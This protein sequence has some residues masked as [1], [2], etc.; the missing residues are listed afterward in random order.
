VLRYNTIS[1]N[2]V[3]AQS[4]SHA[5]GGGLYFNFGAPDLV[6][7][8]I[9]GNSVSESYSVMYDREGGGIYLYG[10]N[11]SIVNSILWDN[12]P[13]E[14]FVSDY[15]TLTVAYSDVQGGQAGVVIEGSPTVNDAG[16]NINADPLFADAANG[17]Y[18]LQAGSPAID[19]GT[20]FF[21]WEGRVVVDLSPD[22]YVGAAP[23][24]GAFENEVGGGANQPPTAVASADPVQ[25]GAPLAVQFS[26]DGSSD[27]D[28]AIVAYAWDFGDGGVSS[29]ANPLYT[30]DTAGTYQ[31]T[32]T[33]TDDDG[34]TDSDTI[35]ITVVGLLMH[36]QD[37]VVTR[38]KNK[39]WERG[40]DT[41]LI[42][43]PDNAPV[44]GALVTARYWGPTQGQVSGTTGADGKV[45]LQTSRVRKAKD[46]WCFEV[47]DVAKDGYT[48]DPAANVVTAQCESK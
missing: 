30:Y 6:N 7:N 27:P 47:L 34:A 48:Y 9:T 12:A 32:L 19:A 40:L 43:D 16:G 17:D 15:A 11:L 39:R 36:V 46:I 24:M 4:N 14:V 20:A 29:E 41:V 2:A 22:E 28:G 35:T 18:R 1:N 31:A 33:V 13:E 38:V 8:T 10:S 37:Q 44:A 3:N 25:G 5:R 21:E 23:D 42:A 45:V 26:A